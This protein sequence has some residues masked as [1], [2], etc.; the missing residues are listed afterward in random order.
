M[1][2]FSLHTD[3]FT[4]QRQHSF[5]Y[6]MIYHKPLT[7]GKGAILVLLDL[8]D[9]F[10]TINHQKLL[11]L[12]NQSFGIRGIALKWVE[13][14]LKDRTQTIQIGSCKS[15]PLTLKYGYLRVLYLA[16]FYLLCTQPLL[17]TLFEN[18]G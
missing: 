11:N 9:A 7:M 16:L 12:L 15:T 4:A 18:M 1:R 2:F 14:Y 8:S 10:D 13:S 3:N 6:K 17:G 5:V